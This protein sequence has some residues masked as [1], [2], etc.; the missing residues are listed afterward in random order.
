[1]LSEITLVLA[2]THALYG[3]IYSRM[4]GT[5]LWVAQTIGPASLDLY[6]MNRLLDGW[7]KT[8]NRLF[9]MAVM[10]A[11]ITG[12]FY[13]WWYGIACMFAGIAIPVN[14][15]LLGLPP[16][17]VG[18]YLRL[19]IGRVRRQLMVKEDL[20]NRFLEEKL[21]E[22]ELMY[23]GTNTRA[24][25]LDIAKRCPEGDIGWLALN[26]KKARFS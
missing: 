6:V 3:L 10:A 11:L 26:H 15:H 2:G 21:V 16:R 19:F 7:P 9:G 4:E 18:F 12:S 14:A 17:N 23:R 22:L 24:P 8:L 1:M 25:N 13:A 5:A 20:A